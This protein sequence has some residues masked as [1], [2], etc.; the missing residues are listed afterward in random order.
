MIAAQSR[1]AMKP[2]GSI[3]EMRTLRQVSHKARK[4]KNGCIKESLK[5][6][7]MSGII[8]GNLG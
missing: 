6:A 2:Q 7:A 5:V 4:N 3:D 8:G 1:Q